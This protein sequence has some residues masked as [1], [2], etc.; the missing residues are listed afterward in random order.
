MSKNKVTIKEFQGD[1]LYRDSA[2][3]R[4]VVYIN[5]ADMKDRDIKPFTDGVRSALN[6]IEAF[7]KEEK[8]VCTCKAIQE[9]MDFDWKPSEKEPHHPDCP[10][11]S[12]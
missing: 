8:R 3:P 4:R 10:R 9:N 2:Q 11:A 1:A 12:Y 7:E 5:V 6:A